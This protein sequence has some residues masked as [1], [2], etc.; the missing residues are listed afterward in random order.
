ME[1]PINLTEL[2]DNK[3]KLVV[4]EFFGKTK[5]M[6]NDFEVEKINKRYS[7][8]NHSD[9]PILIT[10]KNNYFDPV[11][12]VFVNEKQIQ[13]VEPLKWYEYVWMGLPLF[14]A[15]QGGLLG[16]LLGFIAI[17]L[18]SIIFRKDKN[19]IIKYMTTLGINL[20]ITLIYLVLVVIITDMIKR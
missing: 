2:N 3:L 11:P 9:K 6:Y 15:F 5:I 7:I 4:P 20:L 17:R 8:N 19:Q 1:Y 13:L 16:A 12:K 10:L 14:L 18:N